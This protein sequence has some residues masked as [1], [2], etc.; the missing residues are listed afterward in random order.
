MDNLTHSLIGAAMGHVVVRTAGASPDSGPDSSTLAKGTRRATEIGIV[1]VIMNNL[2]DIDFINVAL[3]QKFFGGGGVNYLLHHRGHTHTLIAIPVLAFLVLFAMRRLKDRLL[4]VTALL[5]GMLHLFA[6]FWNEYGVHPFWPFDSRWVY[7]DFVFIIEP[8]IWVLL[9]PML[10][11]ETISPAAKRAYA[12]AAGVMV[13]LL[14]IVSLASG[15]AAL[16]ILSPAQAVVLVG[17]LSAAYGIGQRLHR[18]PRTTH[19][20]LPLTLSLLATVL[21]GLFGLSQWA[22]SSAKAAWAKDADTSNATLQ[23]LSASPFPARPSCW[24]VTA[25]GFSN[26]HYIARIGVVGLGSSVVGLSHPCSERLNAERTSPVEPVSGSQVFVLEHRV[27]KDEF[28]RFAKDC[29]ASAALEFWRVPYWDAARGYAGDLR[30]DYE[31]G[32]R[33]SELDFADPRVGCPSWTPGWTPPL[34]LPN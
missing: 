30:F 13:V 34:T 26:T 2:P 6:D 24:K 29:R 15:S 19:A 14:G 33:F 23:V 31:K 25:A 7:G 9:I 28:L 8:W 1:S 11:I 21:F 27:A 16:R 4:W 12:A 32:L 3:A 22:K 17:A 18:N 10:F 20:L 5:G